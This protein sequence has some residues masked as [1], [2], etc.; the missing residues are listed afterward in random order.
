MAAF[1]DRVKFEGSPKDLVWKYPADNL[2][3][4]TQ[5]IVNETQE[6][7]IFREGRGLDV[8]GPGRHTLSTANVPGLR[9]LINLP[10]G[11]QTPFTAEVYFVSKATVPDL[12]FGTR[13]PIQVMDPRFNVMVP[14]RCFGIFGLRV[15]DSKTFVTVICG[16]NRLYTTDDI[17]T[18]LKGAITTRV[19]DYIAEVIIKQQVSVVEIAAYLEEVSAVGRARTSDDFRKYGLS[20]TDFLLQSIDV[21]DDDETVQKLKQS[22]ATRADIEIMGQENYR[23]KRTFD[24]LEKAAENEGGGTGQ[25]MGAGMGLGLG[26]GVGHMMPG[27]MG[28]MGGQFSGQM[29]AAQSTG[30]TV[31]PGCQHQNPP[32]AKFCAGCGKPLGGEATAKCPKCS[33]DINP[34]SKFC[35]SCGA[36]IG[37]EVCPACQAVSPPGSKFCANCGQNLEAPPTAPPSAPESPAGGPGQ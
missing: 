13:A 26:F 3:T 20:L 10:F 23:M 11:G 35:A 31:C 32:S 21:P 16:Q 24:T 17:S 14:V 2:S 15:D 1:I 22:L 30:V 19:K 9:T 12:K 5:L 34:N 37:P 18:Y 29:A 4:A 27:M 36:K 7:V 8:F 28:Q 6:A 25:M 33:A